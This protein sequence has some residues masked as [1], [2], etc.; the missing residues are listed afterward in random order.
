MFLHPRIRGEEPLSLSQMD[1]AKTVAVAP[2][3]PS[4]G[5]VFDYASLVACAWGAPSKA[6]GPIYARFDTHR[7]VARLPG[8]PY[9]FMSRISKVEGEMGIAKA[10]AKVEVEYDV[11]RD[12]WY[13]EENGAAVMPYSVLMEAALQPCGWLASYIGC[14]LLTEDDLP[15]SLKPLAFRAGTAIRPDPGF[16]RDIDRLMGGLRA[17]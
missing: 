13:F 9:H 2:N 3:G 15:P 5:F 12:A 16:H 10:G 7:K 14:A 11:P 6:F 1:P 4:K 8:P 17:E